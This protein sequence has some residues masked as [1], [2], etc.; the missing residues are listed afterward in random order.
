MYL[1]FSLIDLSNPIQIEIWKLTIVKT[2]RLFI[3]F[4]TD[5]WYYFT[6]ASSSFVDCST[7]TVQF[8]ILE[9]YSCLSHFSGNS[10]L[11]H[12]SEFW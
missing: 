3:F 6:K 7:S 12:D 9:N 8:N 11:Y 4:K 2:T 10:R 1:S 5:F